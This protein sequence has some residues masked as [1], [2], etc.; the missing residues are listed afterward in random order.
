MQTDRTTILVAHRLSTLKDADR[1]VVFDGGRIVEVGTYDELV[2]QGGVFTE[3]VMSA[4]Q[5]FAADGVAPSPTECQD[6]VA[7]A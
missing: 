7:V 3:L 4:E 2:Q 6:G 1:I 5:G